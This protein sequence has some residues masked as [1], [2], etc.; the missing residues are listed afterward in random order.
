TVHNDGAAPAYD[1]TVTDQPDAALTTVVLTDGAAFSTDGWTAADP[2]LR[3]QIPG[4]IAP[5]ASV[6][7]RYT[8][9][10]AP[11][12]VLTDGQKV[13]NTADVPSYFG[14]AAAQRAADGFDYRDYD[15]V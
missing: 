12:S 11:S 13:V 14:V 6:V 10:L 1:V 15:D 9:A 4:P 5:G 8:A 7:L 3:W 2:D